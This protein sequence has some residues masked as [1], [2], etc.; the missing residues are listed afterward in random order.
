MGNS[1]PKQQASPLPIK[2]VNDM[3]NL[4]QEKYLQ[5]KFHHT[6]YKLEVLLFPLIKYT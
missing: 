4:E 5:E 2:S 1:Y 6:C 3:K